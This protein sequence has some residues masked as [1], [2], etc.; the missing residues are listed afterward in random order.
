MKELVATRVP[1]GDK[2]ALLNDESDIVYGSL[3]DCLNQIFM[4][5]EAIPIV[6]G[7]RKIKGLIVA[8]V[9]D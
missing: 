4:V 3:T 2:W 8:R 5:H 6:R 9:H 1:P 7:A